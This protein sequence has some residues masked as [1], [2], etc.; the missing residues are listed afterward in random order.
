MQSG[1][2]PQ[3]RT[4]ESLDHSD[5][6]SASKIQY[7]NRNAPLIEKRQKRKKSKVP[8]VGTRYSHGTKQIG[9]SLGL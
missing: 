3:V 5:G 6:I 9:K 7:N 1:E 8:A 2:L 4:L